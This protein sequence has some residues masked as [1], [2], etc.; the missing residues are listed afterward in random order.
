MKIKFLFDIEIETLGEENLLSI[1][2]NQ[3]LEVDEVIS[4]EKD[5]DTVDFHLENGTA[6]MY[7][8]IMSF[9]ELS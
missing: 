5:E 1:S 6:L 4:Y 2:C 7:V 8:P 9:I 3:I